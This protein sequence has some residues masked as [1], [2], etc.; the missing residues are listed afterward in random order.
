MAHKAQVMVAQAESKLVL[1]E[2]RGDDVEVVA[3]E[4]LGS[5]VC[6]DKTTRSHG[7]QHRAIY[8]V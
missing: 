4:G 1:K 8:G 5:A 2:I 3:R 7:A 6:A